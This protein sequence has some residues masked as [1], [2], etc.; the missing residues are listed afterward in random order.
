MVISTSLPYDDNPYVDD[1]NGENDDDTCNDDA[2][3]ICLGTV[4]IAGLPQSFDRFERFLCQRI[5]LTGFFLPPESSLFSTDYYGSVFPGG[6]F[7]L[8]SKDRI[9]PCSEQLSM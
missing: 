3:S 7:Q 8:N 5:L 2:G 6:V 9:P 1:E 4:R